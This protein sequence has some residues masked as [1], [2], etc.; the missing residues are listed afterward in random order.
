[1]PQL[2]LLQMQCSQKKASGNVERQRPSGDE[3]RWLRV[4][5]LTLVCEEEGVLKGFIAVTI[6]PPRPLTALVASTP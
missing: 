5:E 2:M 1:M 3:N 6:R 4:A